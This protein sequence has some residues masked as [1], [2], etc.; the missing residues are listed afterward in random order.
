MRLAYARL[1]VPHSGTMVEGSGNVIVKRIVHPAGK[2]RLE[3]YR[4]LNGTFGFEEFMFEPDEQ[5]WC[6]LSHRRSVGVFDSEETALAEATARIAWVA[7]VLEPPT[8]P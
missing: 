4:R 8:Q 6:M 2:Y 7:E 1:T 5:V 3:I